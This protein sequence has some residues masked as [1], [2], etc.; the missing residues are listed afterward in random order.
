M[1]PCCDNPLVGLLL[2]LKLLQASDHAYESASTS[3]YCTAPTAARHLPLYTDLHAAIDVC[4]QLAQGAFIHVGKTGGSTLSDLLKMAI[5]GSYTEFHEVSTL[6][7]R[8]RKS[9]LTES[10][11]RSNDFACRFTPGYCF[12][13]I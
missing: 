8:A 7:S 6:A 12:R 9:L 5:P 1:A 13:T 11:R 4:G 3:P 2:S 10:T